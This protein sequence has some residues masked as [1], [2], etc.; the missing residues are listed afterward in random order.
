MVYSIFDNMERCTPEEVQRLLHM[1]S[2]QRQERALKY[3][4]LYGQYACLKSYEML[5]ELM[6]KQGIEA[7]QPVE[8]GFNEHGKPFLR[9][10]KEVFFNIS[11]C[12]NAIAV[13]LGNGPVGVDVERFVTP[14]LSLL[15]RTMNEGEICAVQHSSQPDKEFARLWTRKEAVFKMLGTGIKDNIRSVLDN[16]EDLATIETVECD[17]KTYVCTIAYLKE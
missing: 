17:E 5:L 11:H 9:G 14:T 10:M 8:F 6:E 15:K 7:T 1:V 13:A 12:K 2:G 16:I 3:A 4:H